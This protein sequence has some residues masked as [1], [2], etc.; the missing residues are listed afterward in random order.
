MERTVEGDVPRWIR[1][2]PRGNA[3]AMAVVAAI[4]L[5]FKGWGA[6]RRWRAST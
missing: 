3:M 4:A 5:A 1:E 6:Y 2:A